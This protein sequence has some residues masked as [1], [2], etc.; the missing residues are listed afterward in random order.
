MSRV[1]VVT[2][3]HKVAISLYLTEH[4]AYDIALPLGVLV[5]HNGSGGSSHLCGAVSGVV[6]IYVDVGFWQHLTEVG[7]HFT[8][9]LFFVIARKK[10]SNLFF[11]YVYCKIFPN[12]RIS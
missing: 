6:V 12:S 1:G 5:S 10:Y 11:H 2:V 3:G 4:T 7:N 8:N 9:G